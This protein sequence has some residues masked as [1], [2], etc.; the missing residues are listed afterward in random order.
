MPLWFSAH[1]CTPAYVPRSA[2]GAEGGA[3]PRGA[4]CVAQHAPRGQA[5]S[6][7]AGHGLKQLCKERGDVLALHDEHG[8]RGSCSA[9]P[10]VEGLKTFGAEPG[11]RERVECALHSARG[12]RLTCLPGQAEGSGRACTPQSATWAAGRLALS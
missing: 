8:Y 10:G 2:S 4:P 3:W 6:V 9:V 1:G 12:L 7:G 5:A 11:R